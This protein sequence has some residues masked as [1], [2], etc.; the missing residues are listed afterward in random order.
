MRIISFSVNNFRAINGGLEQN[1]IEFKDSNTI[2]ILG[3]NN[4]GKSSFLRAYE[5]YAKSISCKIEDFFRQDIDSKIEFELRLQ[6]DD[7]DFEKT[8]IAKKADSLKDWLD[9]N[10]ILYIRREIKAN[11][12]G[13]TTTIE[14]A[15]NFTWDNNLNDWV[16]KSY[17]GLGL[18]TVFQAALPTPIFIKAMP[19]EEEVDVIINEILAAKA[20][21]RLKEKDREELKI[22]QEK[23]RELQDK[24]YNAESIKAYKTE[25][26]NQFKN[27]FP[28]TTIELEE[29][30]NVK[31]TQK[32]L[33][34]KFSVQFRRN[35]EDG[36]FDESVP[37]N[38][39]QMGHGAVRSAI[40]SLLLM[41]DIADEY[42]R[43]ENQKDYMVLF[44][45]P[46]LFLHPKLTKQLR[47][48]VYSV[49]NSSTPY[50][51]LCASHSPQMIDITEEKASL[52]RMVNKNDTTTMYQINDEFL[53][54]SK[55]VKTRIELKQEMNEVLRF[56]PFI[57]EA[58]YADEVIL[59]E[60]PTEEIL[61]RGYLSSL[62]TH[63]DLFVVNC[64]T[65]NNIP[66]YQKLFSK[67]SIK[68]HVICDTDKAVEN[69]ID[70]FNLPI[71][72]TGIQGSIYEQFALDKAIENYDSG[73]LSL[74]KETFEPAHQSEDIPVELR[75]PIDYPKNNGKPLNANLY[76]KDI[77]SKNLDHEKISMVP[78][79]RFTNLIMN[80]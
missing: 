3:Q 65:V 30:D 56:N 79:I 31:W 55:G 36:N 34:K 37:T 24:L 75:Y 18:D 8:S 44:E 70:K 17:G 38:Y 35:N 80:S 69:G 2:F 25:V 45:E 32:S 60:G 22:A 59:I 46:E 67:F 42:E 50:Q 23:M 43:V 9:E 72:N 48:L 62:D 76:W 63:K 21:L 1:T 15:Q 64:G 33:E 39:N 61:L 71:Y 73:I 52:V 4:V 41:R 7:Y 14:K 20:A 6:L 51:V 12:K 49:S 26:N 47:T 53:K 13:K 19:T 27:L 29:K 16:E 54:R 57:C 74:H 58:F 77:L 40:F 78:I 5:Y 66:F 68:Y 10:N 11:Q 28:N